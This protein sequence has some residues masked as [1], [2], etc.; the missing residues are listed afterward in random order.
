MVAFEAFYNLRSR[1][2]SHDPFM[3]IKLDMQK[4]F[5]RVEW[6]FLEAVMMKMRFPSEFIKLIMSCV[7]SVSFS[8]LINGS[9]SPRFVSSR[10]IRQGDPLSPFLFIIFSECLSSLFHS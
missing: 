6:D 9:P 2:N 8:V 7:R 10:G 5:D 3:A 4:A 1:A